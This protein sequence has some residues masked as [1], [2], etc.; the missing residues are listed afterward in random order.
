MTRFSVLDLVPVNEGSSA[1]EA[2]GRAAAFAAHAESLGFHRYWV[3]EHHGMPGI[4]SAA[5]AVVLAHIGQATSRIRIGAGGIMLPNHAPLLIAEQFGTLAALFPGRVDLGLGRAPGSDQRVAQAMRR[6][7]TGGP[8]EFPRDV[9]ELQ[10]YFAGD[11][12]LGFQA[13]P[14]AG[15]DVPLWILGSSLYGAQ[16]AAALGL[17]YAFASHFAPGALDEAI[18]IYRRDFRPSA[19]LE[20]PY[21]M[22]GYN[23]FAAD[24]A[25][26]ARLIATSMQQAFVRLRTGQPGKLQPPVPGYYESLP[27]QAQAMLA[28]VLS[29]SSIGT[30]ADVERDLAAFIRRTQVDEIIIG[31]QI[32]DFEARKRS[33]EIAMAA[34]QAVAGRISSDSHQAAP[35]Q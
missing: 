28:D 3:A 33:L 19:Q 7:L 23:V 26:E 14:G 24:T 21:V 2:L 17:P 8:D 30:R 5:T 29:A 16:L 31:G 13:T 11:S 1:S 20:Y 34:G 22:A 27:P 10:A 15:E 4:A 25:E 6:T 12:R 32:H 9:M 35:A 18:A